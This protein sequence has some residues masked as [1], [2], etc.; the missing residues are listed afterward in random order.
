M[1]KVKITQNPE[2][3]VPVEVIADAIV[4]ISA[5]IKKLRAGRLTDKALFLLVQNAA[6]NVGG[7]YNSSPISMREIR[8]VFEGI[9]QLEATYLKKKPSKP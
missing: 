9:D 7:K 4:G 8:A 5:G 1:T 2:K 3:E 6:P